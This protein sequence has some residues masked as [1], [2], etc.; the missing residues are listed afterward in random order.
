MEPAIAT[1]AHGLL[2]GIEYPSIG[3]PAK[4]YAVELTEPEINAIH[5]AFGFIKGASEWD[6]LKRYWEHYGPTLEALSDRL[7]EFDD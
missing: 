2:C 4:R 5:A 3:D 6:G 7:G 1:I